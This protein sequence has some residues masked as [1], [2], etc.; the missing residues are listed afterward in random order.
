[1]IRLITK[2]KIK[3]QITRVNKSFGY[4]AVSIEYRS[5]G[6]WFWHYDEDENLLQAEELYEIRERTGKVPAR[7]VLKYLRKIENKR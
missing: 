2:R 3:Y 5:D 1:M 7:A 6:I 4:D